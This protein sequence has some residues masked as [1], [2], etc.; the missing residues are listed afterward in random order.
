MAHRGDEPGNRARRYEELTGG[1]QARFTKGAV[2]HLLHFGWE[3]WD[4]LPWH[5][6]RTYLEYLEGLAEGSARSGGQH[7]LID[8][9][10]PDPRPLPIEDSDVPA[11]PPAAPPGASTTEGV[12][13]RPSWVGLQVKQVRF[14]E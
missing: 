7:V 4:A 11:A 3:E 13:Q 8:P 2:R 5:Q 10:R 1:P 12:Q 6:Q 14:G 9:V